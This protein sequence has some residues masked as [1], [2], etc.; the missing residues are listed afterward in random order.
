MK[1]NNS[2]SH[3]EREREIKV[4]HIL[5][6]TSQHLGILECHRFLGSPWME[7][8]YSKLM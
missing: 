6:A 1:S 3:I 2:L 8:E 7:G 5:K 4:G